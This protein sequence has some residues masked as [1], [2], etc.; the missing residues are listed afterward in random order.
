MEKYKVEEMSSSEIK[1][2]KVSLENEYE[3]IKNKM[4]QMADKLQ[5]L[6]NEWNKLEYELKKR[7]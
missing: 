1:L 5:E 3:V 2:V 7:G 4:I 6:E